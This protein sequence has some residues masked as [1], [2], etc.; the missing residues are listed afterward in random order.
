MLQCAGRKLLGLFSNTL[1]FHRVI[2]FTTTSE[3]SV[4]SVHALR[5]AKKH[6]CGSCI[7]EV[8]LSIGVF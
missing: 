2:D 1:S 6:C 4:Y 3:K 7:Y 5:C 8:E